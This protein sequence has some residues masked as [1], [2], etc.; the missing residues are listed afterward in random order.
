VGRTFAKLHLLHATQY[1]NGQVIGEEG[2]EGDPLFV[3]GGTRIA[4]YRVHYEDKTVAAVPVAFGEDV[5]DWWFTGTTKGVKRGQVAWEGDNDLAKRLDSRIRLYLT[6]W[7]NPHPGKKVVAID[8]VKVG[9]T[10]AAPF[11]VAITLEAK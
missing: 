2:K 3:A 7:E 9:D 10:P 5:R 1:G 8:Y 4:E 11:C 6:T